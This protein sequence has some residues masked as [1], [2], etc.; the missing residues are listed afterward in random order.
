MD[1]SGVLNVPRLNVSSLS[2]KIVTVSGAFNTTTM[3]CDYSLGGI[4]RLPV[5]TATFSIVI[6]NIPP[7]DASRTYIISLMYSPSG[8]FYCTGAKIN[9]STTASLCIFNGGAGTIPAIATTTPIIQQI[10]ITSSGSAYTIYS[11]VS[12]F[13]A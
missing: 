8:K 10:M 4:F 2:E 12:V 6:T 1:A 13:T 9:T 3:T 5:P 7:N 11:N